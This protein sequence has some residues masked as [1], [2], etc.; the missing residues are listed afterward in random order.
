MQSDRDSEL[1]D[2][3]AQLASKEREWKELQAARV[4]QLEM[5][6]KKA[7]QECSSL[8]ERYQ[9]LREDFQFN[10]AILDERDREL[11]RYDIITARALTEEHNRQEELNQLRMQVGKLE[12]Q[13]ARETEERQ[14][15]LSKSAAQ[16]RL[17][18]D[19][20]K[21]SMAGEI[22][23]QTEE[24]ERMKLD[25]QCRIQEAEGELTLQR[26]EMTAAFD[27]ELRQ[28]EHEFNLKMDEMR[29]VV[30][31]HD[32]MAK[33]LSKETEVH[34]QAQLQATEALKASKEFCQQ[35]QT[36]LQHKDQEI[37]DLTAVKDYRIKELEDELKWMETKLKMEENDHINKY[38]DVVRAL[39]ECDAQLEAQFHANTE[40]MQKA[41]KH[42][43]KLQEN[44]E[45][46]AAQARCKQED[47]QKAMVQKDETI[48]S[49]RREVETT[50]TGW[51]RYISQVS[52]EMVAKDTEL[53]T[54]QERETRRRTEWERSREE[55][56]RYKQQLNAGLKR[57][58]ALEQMR[59][60]VELEWQS[61]CEDMKV[62]HY[63]ANEQLIQD[64]TQARDQG[65]TPKVDSLASEE[66]RRL[67]EQNSILRAVITQMRKDMEGLSHLLPNPQAQPQASSPQP[68]QHPGAP[69]TT[70][71]APTAN[72][73]MAADYT[74]AL[75]QEVSL[76]K[77]RCQSLKERLEGVTRL[78]SLAPATDKPT[79][80]LAPIGG[81]C[82]EKCA[83]TSALTKQEVRVAHMESALANIMEQSALVRQLQEENLY[84]R[85]QQSSGL[86]S[87]DLFENVQDAK[88]NLTLLHT[89]LRQAAFCIARL[90]RE[91]QQLIEMGNCLRAQITTAGLQEPERDSSPE[92]QGDQHD[93]MSALEQLQYQ[94]TTQELQYAL[95]QRAC[96]FAEQLLPGTNNQSPTTK[97]AANPWSQGHKTTDR[98]ESSKNEENTPLVSQSQ[99][100]LDVGPEPTSLQLLKEL[101]EIL[102]RG[103]SPS[104]FSEGEGE[105]SRREVAESGGAGVQMMVHGISAPI[106]SQP[107]SEVQ[108][109]RNLST[110]PSNTTRASRHG[111]P[112]RIS[113]IRNY[114]V[115]D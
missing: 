109:K 34:C 23:K 28:R 60:Q 89:R 95:R 1:G 3:E 72:T 53:I 98:P 33:L 66:I 11:Q 9:Q 36:E 105:Q 8:R 85:R 55:M 70:S 2:L 40:Q 47:Q 80:D 43:V 104:I 20:L 12:E 35:I 41:E 14:E 100:S 99:S 65:L 83:N 101:W 74:Q 82:L 90:S 61:R 96:T 4:H 52:S 112:G 27:S 16:H 111:T 42:I 76:L 15:E 88:S 56:E 87:G 29:A 10:L 108:Q 63:L 84:L 113:K 45:V 37:K 114:N 32:L 5:S 46:L 81:L 49:L 57:E 31:S 18:L 106:H 59:V 92:K 67:Q 62:E 115:K 110:T 26:Q 78:P 68:V 73:Q 93:R 38:E 19:K 69:A 39:K 77:A 71:I 21:R 86:M 51:D 91:K 13:R 103:L 58:R 79:E 64:L 24:Y 75:E 44:M 6:L 22:Q 107:P 48:Q 94:L 50:R 30:L 7:Q 102:D 54:L 25:M 17:Q 97:V